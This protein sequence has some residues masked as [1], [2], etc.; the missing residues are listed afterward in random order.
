MAEIILALAYLYPLDIRPWLRILGNNKSCR[1]SSI[2]S[3]APHTCKVCYPQ[4]GA[5]VMCP[6]RGHIQ[7]CLFLLQDRGEE[8]RIQGANWIVASH[9]ILDHE[10]GHIGI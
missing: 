3:Q 5:E 2:I 6:G 7:K 4:M 9:A 8:I 10:R 1:A